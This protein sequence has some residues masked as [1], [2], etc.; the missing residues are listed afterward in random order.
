MP[1]GRPG[2]VERAIDACAN[3]ARE[4]LRVAED[5]ARFIAG[6]GGLAR[7]LREIRHEVTRCV[8]MVGNPGALLAGRD[9][10]G[11]PGAPPE[12]F[13]SG[14]RADLRGIVASAFKRAEEALRSLEEFSKLPKMSGGIKASAAFERM[15]YR[16]YELERA[17]LVTVPP[18]GGPDA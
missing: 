6:D 7:A 13:G 5:Y 18:E 1:E 3:R 14:E 11:D 9:V 12:G 16:L 10:E 2:S 15:R 17:T 8:E 4:G